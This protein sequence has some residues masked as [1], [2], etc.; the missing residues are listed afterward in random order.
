MV[1][2]TRPD[3]PTRQRVCYASGHTLVVYDHETQTQTHL[4]GHRNPISCVVAT[5]DRA[6]VATADT[7]ADAMI[8][9]WDVDTGEPVRTLPSPHINGGTPSTTLTDDS[10]GGSRASLPAAAGPVTINTRR[11][12]AT[13]VP[14]ADL[15]ALPLIVERSVW[16]PLSLSRWLFIRRPVEVLRVG[17]A[18]EPWTVFSFHHA[19]LAV[20]HWAT[21]HAGQLFEPC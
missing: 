2:L 21:N 1:N 11:K 6:L 3:D 12:R 17:G 9:L 13:R 16:T 19:H 15:S 8:V 18:L 20:A 14:R 4:Q 5:E 10:A 7:G